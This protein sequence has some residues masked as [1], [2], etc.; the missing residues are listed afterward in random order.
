MDHLIGNNNLIS[1]LSEIMVL[2]EGIIL[3]INLCI[4]HAVALCCAGL[5]Y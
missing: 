4:G 5:G 3:L 1:L 2:F